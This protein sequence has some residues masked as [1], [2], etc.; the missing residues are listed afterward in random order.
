MHAR[1]DAHSW[2][3]ICIQTPRVLLQGQ[4]H[5]I[6]FTRSDEYFFV[7]NADALNIVKRS[8]QCVSSALCLYVF[9]Y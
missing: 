7:Y 8:L 6:T 2:I 9:T 4:H 1:N 3:E 5:S